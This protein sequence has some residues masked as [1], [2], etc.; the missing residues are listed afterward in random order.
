VWGNLDLR[1]WLINNAQLIEILYLRMP[2]D[3]FNLKV[4]LYDPLVHAPEK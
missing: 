4:Y 3:D 2:E 1:Y